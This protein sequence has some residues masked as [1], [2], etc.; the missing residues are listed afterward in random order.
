[1]STVVDEILRNI[2]DA[3]RVL[4][5]IIHRTPLDHS[6]TFSRMTGGDIYLK[7]ENLQKTGAFKV[8]GAYYALWK[9]RQRGKFNI[10]VAASSGN[11]A[12]GVAF[13][14]SQ[15]GI[16]SVIVMPEYTSVAKVQA[17][18]GYGAEV[19][20]HGRTYDDAYE[21][22]VQ[23]AE[24]INAVFIHPFDD[25]HVI[26][27][28]GTIG[29]EIEE[30]LP[31]VEVVVVPVGGGGLISGIAVA[32]KHLKPKI[33]IY[34]VQAK[35]AA[36]M[37]ES[38]RKGRRTEIEKVDTIADGIAV[39]K[40]GELTFRIIEE[41]VDDVIAVDDN[42]IIRAMF[43]LLERSKSLA[44]PAGAVGMAAVLS[45]KI[46]VEGK[47]TAIV[48]SGG[49]VDMALL[50]HII[51][52]ALVVEGRE[53]R[54]RGV[55]PDRPIFLKEVLEVVSTMR[56]NIVSIS[57]DRANPVLPPGKAEVEL[58]LETPPGFDIGQLLEEL[59][60]KGFEFKEVR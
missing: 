28:Q 16:K 39:K 50:S 57:H 35:G 13:A 15:L 46:D 48:V 11:H 32:L 44:E 27:G 47:K 54:L 53:V 7:L 2:R 19:V 40:P 6:L 22:A 36:A 43:L 24:E 21:K 10:C 59:K 56:V 8:R 3:R 14:A 42:E 5:P 9:K 58:T 55:L 37:V 1:M 20:L 38:F 52:K 41:Y 26:A 51:Q 34:G 33:K 49:N 12:Q 4:A 23:L 17:T 60:N 29:T 25:K 30:D 31:D 45:G 18:R